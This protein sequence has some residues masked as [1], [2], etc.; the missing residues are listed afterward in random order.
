MRLLPAAPL[1]PV[2]AVR[3]AVHITVVQKE[4]VAVVL[5]VYALL[6]ELPPVAGLHRLIT[7][8]QAPHRHA[9]TPMTTIVAAAVRILLLYVHLVAPVPLPVSLPV[10]AHVPVTPVVVAVVPV[11]PVAAVVPEDGKYKHMF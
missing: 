10:V 7:E 1:T 3:E 9:A 4:F 8:V 6:L 2:Q 11:V 5:P